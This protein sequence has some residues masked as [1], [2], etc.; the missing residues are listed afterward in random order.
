MAVLKTYDHSR[1][2]YGRKRYAFNHHD[3]QF[4]N[5]FR[6]AGKAFGLALVCTLISGC[7][8]LAEREWFASDYVRVVY[9]EQHCKDANP[10]AASPFV[11]AD[12]VESATLGIGGLGDKRSDWQ[13]IARS[14]AFERDGDLALVRPCDG[15][16]AAL[17][18]AQIEVWRTRGFTPAVHDDPLP[19]S[20]TLTPPPNTTY[21]SRLQDIFNCF[22]QA[23]VTSSPVTNESNQRPSS[24]DATEYFSSGRHF[25]GYA[26]VDRYFRPTTTGDLRLS[27]LR[28]DRPRSAWAANIYETLTPEKKAVLAEQYLS[29]LLERGYGSSL[30][31]ASDKA[32]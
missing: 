4:G 29:C 7:G 13:V 16:S 1:S 6:G 11:D 24:V 23:R 20:G 15:D 3:L 22:E 27:M 19:E 8:M 32:L 9:S 21:G 14:I 10:A 18:F 26:K 28:L 2:H 17:E 31:A 12:F 5:S 30:A 25:P